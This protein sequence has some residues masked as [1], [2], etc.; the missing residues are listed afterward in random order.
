MPIYDITLAYVAYAKV[1][2]IVAE[3][4]QEAF[5]QAEAIVEAT[6][7]SLHAQLDQIH[8]YPELDRVDS[9]RY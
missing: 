5:N 4:P 2:V 8:R 6:E 9:V 7:T 3:N 1:G